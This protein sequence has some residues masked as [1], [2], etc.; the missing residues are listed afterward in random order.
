MSR[1]AAANL[2]FLTSLTTILTCD[3]KTKK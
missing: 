3:L 2:P 1:A